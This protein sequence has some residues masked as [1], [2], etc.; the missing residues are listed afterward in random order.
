MGS[1]AVSA[2]GDGS[3]DGAPG[4][5]GRC[6][7]RSPGHGRA[8]GP[9]GLARIRDADSTRAP[10]GPMAWV[11]AFLTAFRAAGSA[12]ATVR[13]RSGPNPSA[14][15]ARSTNH[16]AQLDGDA[17][18]GR[19]RQG[20]RG[21][22]TARRPGAR[23]ARQ[24]DGCR[25]RDPRR[26]RRGRRRHDPRPGVH[27]RR[28]DGREHRRPVRRR[29]RHPPRPEAG[30][31]RGREAAQRPG[32]RRPPVAAPRSRADAGAGLGRRDGGQP[33][34]DPA[35]AVAGPDDGRPVV[36][37]ERRRLQGRPDRREHVRALLPAADDRRRHREA[38]QRPDPRASAWPASRPSARRAAWA[39]WSPPTTCAPRR[40]SRP[41]AWARSSSR[42]RPPSTRPAPAATPAS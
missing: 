12:P 16:V 39:P 26:G 23:G 22:G 7:S 18:E 35:D 15:L 1:A 32:R 21:R 10:V 30:R 41:R 29:R 36:A 31:R 2:T 27:G 20:D 8:A 4:E 13:R 34:R 33:R 17:H 19:R 6:W 24:A 40:P 14:T 42:S 28:R 38:R 3:S 25:A 5:V 9:S 11:D 37:G